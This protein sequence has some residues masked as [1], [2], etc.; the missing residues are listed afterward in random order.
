MTK[1]ER[2]V[3]YLKSKGGVEITG[4]SRKY[5][6]FQ[7]ERA[8]GSCRFYFVGKNGAMRTGD[9]IA[10]SVSLT[11]AFEAAHLVEAANS[12]LTDSLSTGQHWEKLRAALKPFAGMKGGK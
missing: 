7:I 11:S 9:S 3:E 1:A 5:R 12:L 6:T 10:A 8:D 4:R 2:V